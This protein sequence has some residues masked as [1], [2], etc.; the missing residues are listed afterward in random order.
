MQ[1]NEPD[2]HL[3]SWLLL[4]QV[5]RCDEMARKIRYFHEQVRHLTTIGQLAEQ[6]KSTPHPAPPSDCTVRVCLCLPVCADPAAGEGW[7]DPRAEV[8]GRQAVHPGR[9][10]GGRSL[11]VCT[12]LVARLSCCCPSALTLCPF[13]LCTCL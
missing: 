4:S 10:R 5:K 12:T 9:A 6:Q 8:H 13:L 1:R 2:H 11:P 7:H 3:L